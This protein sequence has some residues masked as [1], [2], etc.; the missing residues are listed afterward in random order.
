M[1][2]GGGFGR[3]LFLFE[4]EF[5][6]FGYL[7]DEDEL[8]LFLDVVRDVDHVLFT[9]FGEDDSFDPGAMCGEYFFFDST[10]IEPEKGTL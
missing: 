6:Q 8:D 4:N 9:A 3:S 2:S 10:G 1:A 7:A 5:G